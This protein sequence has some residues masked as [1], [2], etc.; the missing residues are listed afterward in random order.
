MQEVAWISVF[1]FVVARCSTWV[2]KGPRKSSRRLAA[3]DLFCQSARQSGRQSVW[4]GEACGPSD[5]HDV[6]IVEC[7]KVVNWNRKSSKELSYLGF[8]SVSKPLRR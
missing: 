1:K 6:A 8:I 3:Y 4:W 2:S 5:L 7:S